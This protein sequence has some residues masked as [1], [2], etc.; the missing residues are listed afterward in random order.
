MSDNVTVMLTG[1][2]DEQKKVIKELTEARLKWKLGGVSSIPEQLSYI[3]TE[4]C[5]SRFN[6]IGSEGLESHTVEGESMRWSTMI[7]HRTQERYR[8]ISTHRKSRIEA[9]YVFCKGG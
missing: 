5:I 7:S 1:T 4:V 6:K 9:L 8:T 3:V 2:L